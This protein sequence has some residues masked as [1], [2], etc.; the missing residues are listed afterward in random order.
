MNGSQLVGSWFLEAY[1]E[2]EYERRGSSGEAPLSKGMLYSDYL[3]HH[4]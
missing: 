1:S 4:P 3:I 2:K